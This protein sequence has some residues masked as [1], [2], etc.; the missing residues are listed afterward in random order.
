[1][2]TLRGGA[3]LQG[4]AS[5]SQLHPPADGEQ[6][7]LRLAARPQRAQLLPYS[8]SVKSAQDLIA[9]RWATLR[10]LWTPL[11]P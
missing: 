5:T 8:R 10:D 2:P 9:D 11:L 7:I 6:D 3:Y 1:M 4:R